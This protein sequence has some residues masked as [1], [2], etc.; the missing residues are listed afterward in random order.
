MDN[1]S[2]EIKKYL[3]LYSKKMD[4]VNME[5]VFGY[6]LGKYIFDTNVL[7]RHWNQIIKKLSK[8]K[9]NNL[10]IILLAVK[11]AQIKSCFGIS[12]SSS[13]S[14]VVS[15]S[16]K[17]IISPEINSLRLWGGIFVAIPTAIPSAPFISKLGI[18]AGRTTG[19]SRV[20]SKLG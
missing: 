20:S 3:S 19:S 14:F 1:L 9:L 16:S 7:N 5:I 15:G 2:Q 11:P 8:S 6:S 10:D 18:I 4:S 12:F 17:S 13:V